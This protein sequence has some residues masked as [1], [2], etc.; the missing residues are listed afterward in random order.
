MVYAAEL[1]RL[2]AGLDASVA[3]RHRDLLVRVGLPVGYPGDS[4][5]DLLAAMRVDKKS[6]GTRLRF[7]VLAALA[8][9]RILADPDPGVVRAA[10]DAVATPRG[11]AA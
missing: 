1:S 3:A 10:F 2:A 8:A 11:R 6:R 5:E 9:P 7:V 4:W